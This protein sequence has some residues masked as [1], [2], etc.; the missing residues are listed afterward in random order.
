MPEAKGKLSKSQKIRKKTY[1]V[2]MKRDEKFGRESA[3]EMKREMHAGESTKK[4]W[5]TSMTL[6]HG[7]KA[8]KVVI[9]ILCEG[10][11]LEK[12]NPSGD[13]RRG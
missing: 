12:E 9:G 10:K 6:K 1:R 3:Y 8:M 5:V 2:R 13:L 7:V 11:R 4:D